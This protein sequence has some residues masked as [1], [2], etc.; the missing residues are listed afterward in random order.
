M[1]AGVASTAAYQACVLVL[2]RQAAEVTAMDAVYI[3]RISLLQVGKHV[4]DWL[5]VVKGQGACVF[6]FP[7]FRVI[8][9]LVLLGTMFGLTWA[10][11]AALKDTQVNSNGVMYVKG[12]SGEVVK[13]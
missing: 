11:V 7:A 8:F 13:V 10:V 12:D 3:R 2:A 9:T 1:Q 5:C 4:E 6:E